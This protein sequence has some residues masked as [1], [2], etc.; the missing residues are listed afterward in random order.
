MDICQPSECVQPE[1]SPLHCNKLTGKVEF[2]GPPLATKQISHGTEL[3]R[4][5]LSFILDDMPDLK[6]APVR[7]T[8]SPLVV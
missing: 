8:G 5:S 3:V 1:M 7:W 2:R 6:P 4:R